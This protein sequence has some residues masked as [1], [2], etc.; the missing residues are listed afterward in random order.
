MKLP[1]SLLELLTV[2]NGGSVSTDYDAFPTTEPTSWA[3]DHVPFED[4]MGIGATGDGLSL[5]DTPYLVTEWG[6]PSPV[7]LLSGDG[8]Y[9]VALDY[10]KGGT[11]GEP[12]VTWFDTELRTE[13]PLAPNFRSFVEALRAMDSFDEEAIEL[14]EAPPDEPGE[15]ALSFAIELIEGDIGLLQAG[16]R[17][18]ENSKLWCGA[19]AFG[20]LNRLDAAETASL[21]AACDAVATSS[22]K[23]DAIAAMRQVQRELERLIP[24]WIEAG[25]IGSFVD[26]EYLKKR[27]TDTSLD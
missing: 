16:Q 6:L 19:R 7:V 8:H 21:V 4:V 13:L 10:R 5:L 24:A 22:N 27:S 20:P 1:D 11:S 3:D 23:A 25:G 15:A 26:A 2:R 18:L 9:W 12:S 17:S 14:D